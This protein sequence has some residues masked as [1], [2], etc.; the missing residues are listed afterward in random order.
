MKTIVQN[1]VD[2]FLKKEELTASDESIDFE[3]F[4][5]YSILSNIYRGEFSI[6]DISMG[7][8][9]GID[10]LAIVVNG[11]LVTTT[12]E[13][14]DLV[15]RNNYLEVLFVFVQAKMSNSFD[16]ADI[17]N[18][19]VAINDFFND[20]PKFKQ[21]NEIR[22]AHQL[23][24]KIWSYV[25]KMTKGQPI[26]NIYYITTG[27][28]Q[29][30]QSL[31][32]RVKT[33]KSDLENMSLFERVEFIPYGAKN[34]QDAYLQTKRNISCEFTFDKHIVLPAENNVQE[35]YMGIVNFKEFRK[36][37]EDTEGKIKDV[38]YE[39]VRDFLGEGVAVNAGIETTLRNNDFDIFCLLNNGVTI[40]A[41]SKIN[42]G[43]KFVIENYQ[44]VNGCQT[45]H[46]LFN[47]KNLEGMDKVNIPI[48][49]I[50]TNND[51]VQNKII[52]A[53]NNQNA[54]PKEQLE[55]FTQFQKNLELYYDVEKS[56][57]TKLYYERRQKQFRD[58]DVSRPRIVTIR[59]Q[60]KSFA[61]MFLDQ[62]HL[63]SGYFSK[64]YSNNK[65]KM[66]VEDHKY[67]PYYI[68][69]FTMYKLEDCFRKMQ[70]D[71]KYRIAR[72]HILMI[73]RMI[74]M[75]DTNNVPRL[76]S[77]DIEKYCE[78][79]RQI[80]VDDIKTKEYFDKAIEILD[81][82]KSIDMEDQKTLYTAENTEEIKNRIKEII[83]SN[84]D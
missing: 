34:I 14:D 71:K 29:D 3:N 57:A 38:Y 77:K 51:D 66:F 39:N 84:N 31:L 15:K 35:A 73:F 19:F 53:T 32:S 45:S 79:I 21:T 47:N 13:I 56:E 81:E 43:N 6:E 41:N 5:N 80:L 44:I 2:D 26:C 72:Y 65:N 59:E 25:P 46:V 10:G 4:C 76:N 49:L 1:L 36:I 75:N 23:N 52:I 16:G 8:T 68:A 48:K 17:S 7:K 42:H 74:V 50:V 37:I 63:A 24:R 40:V 30:D 58:T 64:V 78:K 54:I 83:S 28:W 60:I 69:S 55:A 11:S 62:P 20:N 18:F 70:I 9:Q 12:D 22:K 67:N 61:S 82:M 27:K 33:H